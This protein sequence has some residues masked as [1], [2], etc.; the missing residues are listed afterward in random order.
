M[1]LQYI[2][3]HDANGD[4]FTLFIFIEIYIYI[5]VIFVIIYN[6]LLDKADNT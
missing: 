3:T 5:F 4:T 6:F 1:A 2:L